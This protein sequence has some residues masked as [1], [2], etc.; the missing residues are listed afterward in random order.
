MRK[1]IKIFLS[2]GL[3]FFS[4]FMLNQ[5]V[6]FAQTTV[7]KTAGEQ[8]AALG[9]NPAAPVAV[10]TPPEEEETL[11][12]VPDPFVSSFPPKP[13]AAG[14]EKSSAPSAAELKDEFDYSSLKVT[15]IVWGA[16]NP[17]AIIDG[18]VMGIGDTVKEAKIVDISKEG[19]LFDYKSKQYLMKREG[20]STSLKSLKEAT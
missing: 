2:G 16:E 14:T 6:I 12:D 13:E 3:I 9:A 1:R 8:A 11:E 19:I 5:I 17:K 20:A 10:S 4:F 7:E 15:G 18:N